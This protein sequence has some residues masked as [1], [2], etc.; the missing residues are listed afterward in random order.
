[1]A[2]DLTALTLGE[3]R[4]A[5]ALADHRHFGRAAKACAVSQPTLSAQ[6]KKLERTLGTRVFERTSH[7]VELTPIG[8]PKRDPQKVLVG[9]GWVVVRHADL[10][11]AL[12]MTEA[13]ANELRLIA[14]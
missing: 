4:Y 5:V 2:I 14:G 7:R 6:I 9:D 3:L 8:E 12:E 1:M 10:K 11:Y 13:F